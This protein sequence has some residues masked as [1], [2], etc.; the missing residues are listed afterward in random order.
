MRAVIGAW[1]GFL[2]HA[3]DFAHAGMAPSVSG[4]SGEL[5]YPGGFASIILAPQVKIK[6]G[7]PVL[8]KAL[9]RI[10]NGY[11]SSS[12]ELVFEKA[13][14]PEGLIGTWDEE[15]G[16]LEFEG[17]ASQG[18]FEKALRT[19]AYRSSA[20]TLSYSWFRTITF[21]VYD[22]ESFSPLIKDTMLSLVPD[23]VGGDGDTTGE[24]ACMSPEEDRSAAEQAAEA[25]EVE[26]KRTEHARSDMKAKLSKT[27]SAFGVIQSIEHEG[28]SGM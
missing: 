9:V 17:E 10:I 20:R 22:G 27:K 3:M 21:S 26:L 13:T 2:L 1:F 7:D 25:A 24:A 4:V 14:L 28:S 18:E 11:N 15:E 8:Q 5:P 6:D 12:D 16:L 23:A 19:V